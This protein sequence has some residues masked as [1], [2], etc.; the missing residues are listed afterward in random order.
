MENNSNTE[1]VADRFIL[2]LHVFE[3]DHFWSHIA[4]SSA[5]NKEIVL[6]P[7]VLSQSEISDDA[8]EVVLLPEKYV[9]WLKVSVHYI[10]LVHHLQP[11]EDAFHDQLDLCRREL[12]LVLDLVVELSSLE[13]LYT[14]VDGV[15]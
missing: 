6:V 10:L 13:Q 2:G 12:M 8:V 14:D 9:F 1:H 5:S 7:V 15:L 3:I 11:F 4:G